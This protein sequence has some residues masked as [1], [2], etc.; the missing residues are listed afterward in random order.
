MEFALL[1]GVYH[2]ATPVGEQR[3]A[4]AEAKGML[5]TADPTAAKQTALALMTRLD[6]LGVGPADTATAAGAGPTAVRGAVDTIDAGL[7]AAQRSLDAQAYLIFAALLVVASVGWM[8]WF[9]KLVQRHRRLQRASTEL[10]ARAA[11][12]RRLA[13]LVRS[14]TDVI[15]RC[16]PDST[17]R[18]ATPSVTA[19]L[20]VDP[21]D[22]VG[23]RLGEL[24]HHEDLVVFADLLARQRPADSELQLRVR[25]TDGRVLHVEGNIATVSDD[26]ASDT[27]VLTFRD[28]SSRVRLESRLTYQAFHDSLTGL[29][30]R[31]LFTDRLTNALTLRPGPVEPLVVLFC[32]LDDFKDVNDRLGHCIGD[33]VLA[34]VGRR[35]ASAVRSGDTAARIGGDEFA[36][37]MERTSLEEAQQ[38][39]ARL[40]ESL[41]SDVEVDGYVLSVRA[42]IGLAAASPGHST[43]EETLRNADVAMYLAKDRGKSGVALYEARLHTESLQRLQLRADLER[44]MTADELVLHYQPTVDLRSGEIVGF[45]ALVRWQHPNLGLLPPGRFVPIAEESG[46]VV[47]LGQWVLAQAC[48]A[49]VGMHRVPGAATGVVEGTK[50]DVGTAPSVAV[51]VAALQLAEDCFVDRV[52]QVLTETG[53]PA[54]RLVLEITET[55][56]LREMDTVI[57]RL[58][59][60]RALGVRIAIDD[61]GTGYSSLAYLSKLPLDVLKVDKSFIDRVTDDGQDALVTAAIIA[62]S[63]VMQLRTVAEGVERTEQA[64]WLGGT[65]C[66]YGQG[67]LWSKPVD[68]A[69]AIRLLTVPAPFAPLLQRVPETRAPS[70]FAPLPP[71]VYRERGVTGP[72]GGVADTKCEVEGENR[73][74]SIASSN[75]LSEK[76]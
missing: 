29:S 7:T 64:D 14:S 33:H 48:R 66:D 46:L 72:R 31:Q 17:V 22:L 57:P 1:A 15:V 63:H 12:E 24:V 47:A 52:V 73:G 37:L 25:H 19:V 28:V 34:E 13:T 54:D 39:A 44:A 65:D 27:R 3:V 70:E 43:A 11:G 35:F 41:A 42:S 5:G 6:A 16:A 2:R 58:R 68:L 74:A 21:D 18:Y 26:E 59:A 20:G 51:N 45:E 56:A 9:R 30:N 4:V 40:Q 8:V 62:M 49:A 53:L 60:L 36:V 69:E 32:D 55:V 61:F 75:G 71:V 23:S 67:F 50:L 10:H 38:V 76:P